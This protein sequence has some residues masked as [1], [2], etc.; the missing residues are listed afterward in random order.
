MSLDTFIFDFDGTLG[1]SQQCIITSTKR[2]F[3][4]QNMTVPDEETIKYYIGIPLETSMKKMAGEEIDEEKFQ[5]LLAEFRKT[6]L[7]IEKDCLKIFPDVK[8]LLNIL[9]EKKIECFVLSSKKDSVLLRNLKMLEIE[10]YFTEI[11]GPDNLKNH[12]PHPEGIE[13]LAEKYGFDREKTVMIGD[14]IFDIQMGKAAGVKTCAVT[15]GIHNTDMLKKE[16]PDIMIDSPLDL[17][18][19]VSEK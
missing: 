11:V 18:K 10:D 1:D 5:N 12:K 19:C 17:I 15:W 2:A 6:L 3:E 16:N 13:M 9:R 4:S 8:E 7:E 14:A